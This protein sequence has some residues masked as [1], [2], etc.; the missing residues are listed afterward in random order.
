MNLRNLMSLALTCL[1]TG[2]GGEP[3]LTAL[4]SQPL[5]VTAFRDG[6]KVRERLILPPSREQELLAAWAAQ[7]KRGWSLS[8]VTYAPGTL[9][10]G[11]NFSLNIHKSGVILNI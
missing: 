6:H 2:C 1:L 3:D 4:S 10:T 9:V 8:Y 5:K 11:T 7:H